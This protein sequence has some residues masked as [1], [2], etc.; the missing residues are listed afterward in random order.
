M[1]YVE[2]ICAKNVARNVA[3]RLLL[4]AYMLRASLLGYVFS[5]HAQVHAARNVQTD[6][7]LAVQRVPDACGVCVYSFEL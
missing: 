1:Q 3:L 7:I 2:C 4:F 6:L 5:A